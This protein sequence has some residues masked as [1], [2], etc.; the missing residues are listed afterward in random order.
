MIFRYS[1]YQAPVGPITL[2]VSPRGVCALAFSEYWTQLRDELQRRLD[3]VSFVEA[4]MPPDVRQRLDA[5]F[6][7]ELEALDSIEVD[8]HGTPFQLKVWAELRKIPAGATRSYHELAR[9]VGCPGGARAA[10]AANGANPVS[11][12]VPCH[13][14]IRADG[15]I[16]GY[17]GGIERKIWLLRHEGANVG[18][19]DWWDRLVPAAS[20]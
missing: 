20:V 19:P 13:R 5:Y 6:A 16:G 12:I 8:L 17:G 3:A 18:Q 2:A 1:H 14:V 7:G 11:L 9:A 10:G 15:G 4:D